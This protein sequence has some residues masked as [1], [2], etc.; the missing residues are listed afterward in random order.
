MESE[1]KKKH[2]F[3][4]SEPHHGMLLDNLID[5]LFHILDSGPPCSIIFFIL[6]GIVYGIP[7]DTQPDICSDSFLTVCVEFYLAFFLTL[8]LV[9]YLAFFLPLYF[10]FFPAIYM[11]LVLTYSLTSNLTFIWH[12]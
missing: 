11:A 6:F 2:S 4:S 9:F 7:F 8:H 10:A 5:I 1:N 3:T 12:T